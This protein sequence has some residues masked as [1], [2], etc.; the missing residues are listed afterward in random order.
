MPAARCARR[1]SQL[2]GAW[3]AVVYDLH[4]RMTS[5]TCTAPS[6]RN[7]V[8]SLSADIRMD[9]SARE[10][11]IPGVDADRLRVLSELGIQDGDFDEHI[12]V[13]QGAWITEQH[14]QNVH[15]GKFHYSLTERQDCRTSEGQHYRQNDIVWDSRP[16][17]YMMIA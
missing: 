10:Q 7:R 16:K 9:Y 2:Q 5:S 14:W 3:E 13:T 15:A 6:I 17:L 4:R 12:R 8:A 1:V 11:H